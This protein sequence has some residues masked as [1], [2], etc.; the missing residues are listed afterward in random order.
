MTTNSPQNTS[1]LS[2]RTPPPLDT[3]ELDVDEVGAAASEIDGP[4]PTPALGESHDQGVDFGDSDSAL[5]N[6]SYYTDTQSLRS[7]IMKYRE[8]HGR[9]YHAFGEDP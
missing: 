5:D 8:E 6:E 7:S 4:Q 1:V 3:T 2:S 9:T